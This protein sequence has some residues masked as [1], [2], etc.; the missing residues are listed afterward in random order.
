M[1]K[2]LN[3]NKKPIEDL[4]LNILQKGPILIS[5]LIYSLSK[6]RGNTT[7]QGVYRVLRK[8]N[9]EEKIVINKK[10]V[11]LNLHFIKKMN[12]FF[13]LA[14][15]FYISDLSNSND[16]LWLQDSEKI[17]Y[18]FKNLNLLDAFWSHVFYML[19]ESINIEEPV[20][21]Y[22]PHNW[23]YYVRQDTEEVILKDLQEKPRPVYLTIFNNSPLDKDSQISYRKNNIQCNIISKNFFDKKDF[24]FS[25]MGDYIL[26][27]PV[28]L[29]IV[30][31]INKFFENTKV[32]DEKAKLELLSI[33]SKNG[34]NKLIISR[35]KKK[36]EEY[37]KILSKDFFIKK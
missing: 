5:D 4:L 18:Y 32:F 23:F 13:S 26:E 28:D 21:F 34:R 9:N 10:Q 20:F 1:K 3:L 11:S 8:L 25:V 33:V 16:F 29:N 19:N 24:Y 7:K 37:R 2:D 22:M 30:K 14:Q 15:Y 35:N 6:E 17:S 12:N 31:D 36:A 27:T